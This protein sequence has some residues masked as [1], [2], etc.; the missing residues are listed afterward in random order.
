MYFDVWICIYDQRCR[1]PILFVLDRRI[2]EAQLS[3]GSPQ[4]LISFVL[5]LHPYMCLQLCM[6]VLNGS[7]SPRCSDAPSACKWGSLW[8]ILLIIRSD[9]LHWR[10]GM[11]QNIPEWITKPSNFRPFIG[12]FGFFFFFCLMFF[13][14]LSICRPHI[15]IF[16]VGDFWEI[17]DTWWIPSYK[18]AGSPTLLL[19]LW[20]CRKDIAKKN[21][22]Y[23]H[24]TVSCYKLLRY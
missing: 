7:R 9:W 23:Q 24:N 5:V 15:E 12:P 4:C 11:A 10:W 18:C 21:L 3:T 2:K 8:F 19:P 20:T 1:V 14:W 16:V 13:C 17:S 6:Q 22:F